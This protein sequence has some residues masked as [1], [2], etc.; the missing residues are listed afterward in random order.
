MK[1]RSLSGA[2]IREARR[3]AKLTQ[4]KISGKLA[5][6]GVHLDRSSIGKIEQEERG[7][8]DFEVLAIAVCLNVNVGWLL[9]FEQRTTFRDS[10]PP[11]RLKNFPLHP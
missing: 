1:K 5:A 3:N 9:G 8:L 4:D 10:F 6:K 2:K 7:V 11:H